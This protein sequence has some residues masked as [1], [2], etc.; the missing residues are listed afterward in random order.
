MY[1]FKRKDSSESKKAKGISKTSFHVWGMKQ[2]KF[3]E[4]IINCKINKVA[5]SCDDDK[6]QMLEDGW[7]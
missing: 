6:I 4:K 1:T 3:K 5:L 7:T 2:I